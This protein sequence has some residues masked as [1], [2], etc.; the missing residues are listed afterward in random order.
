M[1]IW[2][3]CFNGPGNYCW[4]K[5]LDR[6]LPGKSMKIAMTK[7]LVEKMTMSPIWYGGFYIVLNI[8]E[9]KSDIFSEAKEK[10]I[11]TYLVGCTFWIPAQALNF[12]FVP[13]VYRVAYVG[14]AGF[15]WANFLCF[16]KRHRTAVEI[17][18]KS[19]VYPKNCRNS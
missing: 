12:M 3:F 6:F 15:I 14:V 5:V 10:L 2:G 19:S 16:M 9:G 8:M 13:H 17:S 7:V 1:A 18:P 11:P 4:Y